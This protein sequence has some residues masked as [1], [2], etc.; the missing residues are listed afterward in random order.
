MTS[1]A[2]VLLDE[3]SRQAR[4]AIPLLQ[5]MGLRFTEFS[6]HR[7]RLEMPL[8]PNINDKQT[9]FGGSISALA[10]A[11]G[12]ALVTLWLR[13]LDALHDWARHCDVM[14]VESHIRYLAPATEDINA[15]VSVD[16]V[17]L[18]AFNFALKTQGNA[19]VTLQVTVAQNDKPVAVYTGNYK[20]RA[21]RLRLQNTGAL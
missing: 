9:G 21:R 13:Q 10:T 6:D 3:F 7:L 1:N 20:A 2:E 4:S 5:S 11:A 15:T 17:T 8:A 14:V 12:W 16:D 18:Q 19:G